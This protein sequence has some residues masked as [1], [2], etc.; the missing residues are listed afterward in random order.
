MARHERRAYPIWS[1]RSEQRRQTAQSPLARRVAAIFALA[2]VA[3][4]LQTAAGMLLRRALARTKIEATRGSWVFK[5]TPK[6]AR[7]AAL[8]AGRILWR[9]HD[10]AGGEQ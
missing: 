8:A 7:A 3:P 9:L 10:R 5:Q 4:Q 6:R 1:A 2:G